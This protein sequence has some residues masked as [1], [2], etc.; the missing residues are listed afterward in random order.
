MF[1]PEPN[2][3]NDRFCYTE[4]DSLRAGE[5]QCDFCMNQRPEAPDTCKVYPNG[6][7][8][9]VTNNSFLCESIDFKP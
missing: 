1:M 3:P 9:E 7:P 2:K 8:E 6:K 5:C 4:D